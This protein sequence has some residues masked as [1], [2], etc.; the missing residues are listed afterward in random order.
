MKKTLYLLMFL[1]LS[2]AFVGCNGKDDRIVIRYANWNLGTPE[3]LDTNME[4][5][6]INEFMKKYPEIKIE[7]IERPKIPHQRRHGMD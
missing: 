3:S 4:R 1:L 2:F 5:L 7:I 6:M